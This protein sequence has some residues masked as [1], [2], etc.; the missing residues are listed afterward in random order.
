MKLG[1]RYRVSVH[2]CPT[3]LLPPGTAMG[4]VSLQRRRGMCQGSGSGGCYALAS[5][6]LPPCTALIRC[7]GGKFTGIVVLSRGVQ[8]PHQ[9]TLRSRS[10]A[11]SDYPREI[12][13]EL[14]LS[15][16]S[17][18]L[19]LCRRWPALCLTRALRSTPCRHQGQHQPRNGPGTPANAVQNPHAVI[20]CRQAAHGRGGG[21]SA[22]PGPRRHKPQVSQS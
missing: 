10:T 19:C 12:T 21:R 6:S 22:R 8:C 18:P 14:H 1:I 11:M 15:P 2:L 13:Q 5:S 7:S 17:R 4:R 3:T 9:L 16:G 20:L